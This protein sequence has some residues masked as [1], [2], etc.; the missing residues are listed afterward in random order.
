[1]I[2]FDKTVGWTA[3]CT[4][5]L[6]RVENIEWCRKNDVTRIFCKNTGQRGVFFEPFDFLVSILIFIFSEVCVGVGLVCVFVWCVPI[7]AMCSFKCCPFHCH[8]VT[9]DTLFIHTRPSPSTVLTCLLI[10]T[11]LLTYLLSV[12]WHWLYWNQVNPLNCS[13]IRWLHLNLFTAIQV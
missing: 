1:M 4:K 13:G 9:L 2:I 8:I 12:T 6:W 3:D 5:S 11:H 10:L 7:C